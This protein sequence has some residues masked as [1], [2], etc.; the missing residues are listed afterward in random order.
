MEVPPVTATEDAGSTDPVNYA[1]RDDEPQHSHSDEA[2]R[3]L[4][5]AIDELTAANA[6]L[7]Q[8]LAQSEERLMGQSRLAALGQISASIGH[9][10]ANPL[11]VIRNALERLHGQIGGTDTPGGR[12]LVLI[13]RQVNACIRLFQNFMEMVHSKAVVKE[14]VDLGSLL[15]ESFCALVPP[16]GFEYETRFEPDPFMV[17][18]DPVQLRQVLENLITNAM[19]AMPDGGHIGVEARRET[20]MDV[21]QVCDDGPGVPAELRD[22]LFEP[23]VTGRA[24]GTGLGLAICRQIVERHGGSIELLT[25]QT[26]GATF[27]IRL[28]T[29]EG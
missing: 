25:A 6:M 27:Q 28:P 18:A 1:H 12:E 23:L 13:R 20:G 19:Q 17:A 26:P 9:Q 15:R 16:Q 21:I 2:H 24:K 11:T 8:K 4:V 10:L 14:V 5:S 22:R 7:R 29:K 3:S